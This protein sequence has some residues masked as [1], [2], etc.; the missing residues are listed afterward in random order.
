MVGP[1]AV[2]TAAHCVTDLATGRRARESE[3]TF[4]IESPTR[5]TTARIV[6]I[7]T[8]TP[9]WSEK[10]FDNDWAVLELDSNPAPSQDYLLADQRFDP[11]RQGTAWSSKLTMRLYLAGYSGDLNDGRF[12]TLAAGCHYVRLRTKSQAEHRCPSWRG[13]SGAPVL[14]KHGKAGME[15]YHVIGVHVWGTDSDPHPYRLRGMRLITREVA[16]LI[17]AV[18]GPLGDKR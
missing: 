4:T 1:R 8:P 13:A 12:L 18:N 2:L 3:V 10:D 14:V 16:E 11:G 17:R 15:S 7:H 6:A 9:V 5:A